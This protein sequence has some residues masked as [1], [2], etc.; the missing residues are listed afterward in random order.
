MCPS[1]APQPA[2]LLSLGPA[3]A[4]PSGPSQQQCHDGE[5]VAEALP[6]GELEHRESQEA[7]RLLADALNLACDDFFMP[8]SAA[9]LSQSFFSLAPGMPPPKRGMSMASDTPMEI[10]ATEG[11][12]F[13]DACAVLPDTASMALQDPSEFAEE[14]WA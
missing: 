3:I 6:F 1:R 12:P 9:P 11:A 10:R 2:P 4:A 13:A 8:A 7:R 5:A 14:V